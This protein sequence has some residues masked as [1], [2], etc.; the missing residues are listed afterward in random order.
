MLVIWSRYET[1][2]WKGLVLVHASGG[3][4]NRQTLVFRFGGAATLTPGVKPLSSVAA[5]PFIVPART[6]VSSNAVEL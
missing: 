6:V 2:C 4:T 5:D 3:L 1:W